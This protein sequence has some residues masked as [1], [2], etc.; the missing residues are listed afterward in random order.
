MNGTKSTSGQ[1]HGSSPRCLGGG[2]SQN[3]IINK[4]CGQNQGQPWDGMVAP[5]G[6]RLRPEVGFQGMDWKKGEPCVG[7]EVEQVVHENADS[8]GGCAE[9]GWR[10]L[11][12]HLQGSWH[13]HLWWGRW[14]KG[15]HG[16]DKVEL[17]TKAD[18]HSPKPI[19]EVQL[20]KPHHPMG[21]CFKHEKEDCS[22]DQPK[23]LHS[24]LIFCWFSGFID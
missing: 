17:L 22:E 7:C 24:R 16:P 6:R 18:N 13:H 21:V 9:E 15:W 23:V 19:T 20:G 3:E 4:T 10:V 1:P 11:P 14:V 12:T 5:R 2:N 8:K